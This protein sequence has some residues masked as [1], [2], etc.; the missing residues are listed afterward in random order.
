MNRHNAPTPFSLTPN[1]SWVLRWEWKE[2][3]VST[4]S[5]SAG[6]GWGYGAEKPLKQFKNEA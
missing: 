1:F 2:E 5:A 4:V 6:C 3:T